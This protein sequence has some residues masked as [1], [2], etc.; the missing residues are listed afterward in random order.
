MYG[1]KRD[2]YER[3]NIRAEMKRLERKE[4]SCEPIFFFFFFKKN[5]FIPIIRVVSYHLA[6]SGL[7]S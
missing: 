4:L 3:R 6:T 5:P 7:I 1:V 2:V